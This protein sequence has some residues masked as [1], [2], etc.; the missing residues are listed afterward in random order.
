MPPTAALIGNVAFFGDD[1]SPTNISRLISKPIMKKK[2][3]INPSLIH[4]SKGFEIIIKC[5]ELWRTYRDTKK[6][7]GIKIKVARS[8]HSMIIDAMKMYPDIKDLQELKKMA[9]QVEKELAIAR[10]NTRNP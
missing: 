3:V 10:K 6:S 2:T 4:K 9:Q 7:K 5:V 8:I 1:N